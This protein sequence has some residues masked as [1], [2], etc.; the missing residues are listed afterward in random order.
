VSLQI[1]KLEDGIGRRVFERE[2]GRELQLTPDGEILLT[3]RAR[4]CAWATRRAR[5]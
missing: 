5:A 1:K 3:T 2:P 4:C